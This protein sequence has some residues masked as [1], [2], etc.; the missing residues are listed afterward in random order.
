MTCQIVLVARAHSLV[1]Y[2]TI[3]VPVS[4]MSPAYLIRGGS[5]PGPTRD[6]PLTVT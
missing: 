2:I 3:H 1:E 5:S 4:D 6:L